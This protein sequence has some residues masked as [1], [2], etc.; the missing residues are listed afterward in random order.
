[1]IGNHDAEITS[2]KWFILNILSQ[3][4]ILVLIRIRRPV[5]NEYFE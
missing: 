5:E 2:F 3:V 1:M 4:S